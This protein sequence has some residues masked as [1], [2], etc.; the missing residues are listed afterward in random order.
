MCG[1]ARLRLCLLLAFR[2]L[3]FSIWR[4]GAGRSG[5]QRLCSL[6]FR[7]FAFCRGVGVIPFHPP[8]T[9]RRGLGPAL[10][11]GD[12]GVK[13]FI[14][15]PLER[16]FKVCRGVW[17]SHPRPF[18]LP[19]QGE[20]GVRSG[21]PRDRH[22]RRRRPG[23]QWSVVVRVSGPDPLSQLVGWDELPRLII[24]IL[25]PFPP[26]AARASRLSG[27]NFH[28]RVDRPSVKHPNR[29][30]KPGSRFCH[31]GGGGR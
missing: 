9:P 17:H 20:L 16:G 8:H 1:K 29:H 18:S 5:T 25:D 22:E 15:F 19:V 21:L 31:G 6:P 3:T 28:L 7:M 24:R 13:E 27:I 12:R 11:G 2:P 4:W 10:T 23:G 14:V 26:P 30:S